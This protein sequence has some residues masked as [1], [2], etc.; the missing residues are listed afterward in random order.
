MA[1]LL[2]IKINGLDAEVPKGV[3]VLEAAHMNNIE[4]PTLCYLKKINEIGAC[5]IC[6]VQVSEGG[7]PKRLV[8]SCVY[9]V[10]DGMEIFTN[11][12]KVLSARKKTLELILSTHD[13]KCLS[14]ER[15]G[16]CELQ[17]LAKDYKV[18][19]EGY[20]DGAKE[21]YDIDNSA[22]HM[23]RNNNKC[24]LCRRCV[25]A[26]T[27]NQCV[28]VIGANDRGFKTH[29][30]SNFDRDLAETSCVNCGQC[31]VMCPV[32]ALCEKDSTDEVLAAIADPEKH[33]IVQTAPAVRAGLGEL[34][35]YP[36]GTDV[37]GKMAA[38]LRRLGFDKVFDTDFSADLTIMEEG[39]E[40]IQRMTT[41]GVL[42]MFT[43]CSP[44]WVKFFEAYYPD[45][46]DHLS[47]C[48][49]PQQM[50]GAIAKSYYA[51]KNNLD[52]K[53]IVCVS[54]MPCTAKKFEHI[55]D[56]QAAND[57]PDVDIVLTTR[58]LAKLVK[59]CGINFTELPDEEFDAPMGMSTGAGVIFGTSGGVMEAALRTAVEKISGETLPKLEFTD[60]R[61]TSENTDLEYTDVTGSIKE[62][63]YKVGDLEI[64]V[65]IVSGLSNAKK[66]IDE[67]RA[68]KRNYHFIEVMCCPGGCINGGGQPHVSGN[69]RN[70]SDYRFKR[71]G[72]LYKN[73]EAKTLRKSHENPAI[74]ELYAT[75]LGEPGSHKAHELLHTSY[76]AREKNPD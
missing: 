66:L 19:D 9:P 48:K 51:E 54:I 55:R 37:E 14:C 24:V 44:G 42:P 39:T 40:F 3:T 74:I 67:V 73:D 11:T 16:N 2:K 23:Y 47:T 63:T 25:A 56:D 50:F 28:G 13:R 69:V 36:I 7:R 18:E 72:V 12:E 27:V 21:I 45:W 53:N 17:K 75:F 31:I 34:F 33:V 4:I 35:G 5:R 76:L 32:G 8:A 62:A 59:R 38:A 61:P 30:G 1:D 22:A 58:E 15:S 20:Y 10:T 46:L 64:K 26:C 65:A 49:S 41:G 6:M 52:P 70:F 60:V 43:S 29:I 71:A 57:V 68:G